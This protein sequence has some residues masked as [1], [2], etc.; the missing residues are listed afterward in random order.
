MKDWL[1]EQVYHF[2]VLSFVTIIAIVTVMGK[3][4]TTK[5]LKQQSQ[6]F[7][8]DMEELKQEIRGNTDKIVEVFKK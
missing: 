1:F 5:L 7:Y 2:N 6:E 8:Q 3:A 4:N